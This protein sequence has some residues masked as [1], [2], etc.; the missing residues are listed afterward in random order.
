MW[1]RKSLV[2]GCRLQLRLLCMACGGALLC[3]SA[4]AQARE[5]SLG[6][7]V[8]TALAYHPQMR[9]QQNKQQAA[10]AAIDAARWDFWPTPSASVE[11]ANSSASDPSYKGDN[12]VTYL[13]LQQPLWTGGRLTGNLN[14]AVARAKTSDGDV[15]EAR[16]QLSLRVLQAWSD[17][18]VAKEKL[19]A[20]ERSLE[21][22]KRFLGLVE[23]R[24]AEGASALAD[25]ALAKSRLS[26]LMS[27]ME[28]V[29][30]QQKTAL[31]TLRSVT[32]QKVDVDSLPQA[33]LLVEPA[34]E[35]N[36]DALLA[37]ARNNSPQ[38]SKAQAAVQVALADME[39]AKSSLSPELYARLERQYGSFQAPDQ[40][41]QTRVFVG[42]NTSFGGG[43]SRL[44]GMDSAV[45]QHQAALDELQNQQ[46][47]LEEQI[48]R[49]LALVQAAQMRR[50]GLEVAIQG[51]ADVAESYERQFLAG[52][53]QW[54]DLVNSARELAQSEVQL[55][56]VI[57]AQHLSAWKLA[58]YTRGTEA[59]FE[60]GRAV[61]ANTGNTKAKP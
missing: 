45:A 21:T 34:R 6:D 17:A 31:D 46:L 8:N 61:N 57:G 41:A 14:K 29:R 36:L 42:L 55:A 15:Q 24:Q 5:M 30:V 51:A 48:T 19:Q 52:R 7:L 38:L 32:G 33:R 59:V 47:T 56:D 23:R 22:N 60:A 35:A 40:A 27:D 12:R 4:T 50:K 37:G 11:Q 25:V 2:F 26:T 9:G 58:I 10:T 1:N 53:K 43:L 20:Y 49:E 16:Q 39:I 13:R 28:S 54:L 3:L 18:L 44:S